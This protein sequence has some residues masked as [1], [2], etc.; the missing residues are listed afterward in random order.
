MRKEEDFL[1]WYTGIV[2]KAGLTDKRYPI[3]GMNVWT[4][5]GWKAMRLID[6]MTRALCEERGYK[7]VNFPLLIPETEF[8][9]EE[10]HI[11]GFG[12]EVY[13]VTHGGETKLDIRLLLR[14][15]SE[16]AMY[17]MF[18]LWLRSHAD[19]PLKI[20]Q[21]VNVF[22]YETKMTRAFMRVREIHFFEGHT[23]Q[24]DFEAAEA[25]VR[26]DMEIWQALARELALPYLINRRPEWDKF[27]GAFYSL[28]ADTITPTGKTLQVATIHHYKDNFAKP[29]NI[30]YEDAD[31]TRKHAH[32][33][34][35]GM[36]ERLI[37]AIVSIHGDDKGLVMPPAVAPVQVVVVPI[38]AK[39]AKD[40]PLEAARQIA[41]ALKA[42]GLRAEA[43]VRDIRPGAK[44][45]EHELRGVPLRVEVGPRDLKEGTV[46][47][48]P[49]DTGGKNVHQRTRLK[50]AVR[51]EFEFLRERML[52]KAKRVIDDAVRAAGS[53]G[54]IKSHAG[55][56][57]I[58][59]CGDE[60]C[61]QKV[62]AEAGTHI[63]GTLEAGELPAAVTVPSNCLVCGKPSA[64]PT[65]AG[66]TY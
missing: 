41:A 38:L 22:R 19:L 3:K 2:E 7:E 4:P 20:F 27:A 5:Y 37:G 11:K 58:G 34:T 44:Y 9:K 49:R 36:S 57:V 28:G 60:A 1:A 64:K 13:W 6:E 30:T 35:Y 21:I 39:G 52:A 16:T 15:T 54:E 17:P 61:G 14:P 47:V 62:E 50:E 24:R 31:G 12:G 29:Y 46:V 59:W 23:A 18:A 65:I 63:L 55:V 43:D 42:D 66:G 45:Y 48:V 56:S 26:E 53:V 10:D 25:Q 32:Q 40:E 8:K 51:E 33:T